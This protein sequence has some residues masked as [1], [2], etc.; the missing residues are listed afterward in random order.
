MQ[1][2]RATDPLTHYFLNDS[3]FR[4][5]TSEAQRNDEVVQTFRNILKVMTLPSS[6][7]KLIPENIIN[8]LRKTNERYF[9][10][11]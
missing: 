7:S 2:L 4:K 6:C 3:L 11:K 9:D 5:D 10:S 8:I 1:C